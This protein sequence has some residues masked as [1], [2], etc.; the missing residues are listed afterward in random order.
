[1]RLKI[2]FV[3]ALAGS[4]TGLS[5]ADCDCVYP[6][7]PS[8]CVPVCASGKWVA[9]EGATPAGGAGA[10]WDF[11]FS[12]STVSGSVTRA[13]RGSRDLAITPI[14]D[15]KVNGDTFTFSVMQPGRPGAAPTKVV[16][17]GRIV[18][19]KLEITSDKGQGTKTTLVKAQ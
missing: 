11:K 2:V 10:T 1:M 18:E 3:L 17:A 19:G 14:T 5:A 12:G 15:G 13:G 9:A 7:R 4:S 8:S 6:I 16:Y